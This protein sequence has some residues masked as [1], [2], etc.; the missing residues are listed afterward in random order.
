MRPKV[1]AS[2]KSIAAAADATAQVRAKS[3]T[4]VPFHVIPTPMILKEC[5]FSLAPE[6]S[7]APQSEGRAGGLAVR[8]S[9]QPVGRS[10]VRA[11]PLGAELRLQGCVEL[12]A[13]RSDDRLRSGRSTRRAQRSSSLQTR[14]RPSII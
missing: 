2:M 13:E 10:K 8:H 12:E 7:L 11:R 5:V 4:D 9:G 6:D 3:N 1:S 14:G